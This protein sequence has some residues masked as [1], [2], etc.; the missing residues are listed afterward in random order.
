[1]SFQGPFSPPHRSNSA[2]DFQPFDA[3][4]D[5]PYNG[6]EKYSVFGVQFSESGTEN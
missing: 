4:G 3:L 5:K 2:G 6:K 1:M